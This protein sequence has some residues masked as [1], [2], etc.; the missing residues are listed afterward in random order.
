MPES[1]TRRLLLEIFSQKG[2]QQQAQAVGA[3]MM[4]NHV[5]FFEEHAVTHNSQ[6]LVGI[7][8][9]EVELGGA[10]HIHDG[11]EDTELTGCQ[12]TDHNTTRAKTSQAQLGK[13]EFFGDID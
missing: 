3:S 13:T 2:K 1:D 9:V 12:S 11:V 7:G 6:S 5:A 8:V 10:Q 4:N